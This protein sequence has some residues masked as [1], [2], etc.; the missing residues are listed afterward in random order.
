MAVDIPI[1]ADHLCTLAH[2]GLA[3][4]C[5]DAGGPSGDHHAGVVEIGI[6][7]PRQGGGLGSGAHG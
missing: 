5:A 6:E 2:K 1:E 4:G 7:G 3:D